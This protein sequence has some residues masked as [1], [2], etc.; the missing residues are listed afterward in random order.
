VRG[1][2]ATSSGRGGD[3][4]SLCKVSAR[5]ARGGHADSARQRGRSSAARVDPHTQGALAMKKRIAALTVSLVLVPAVGA[6]AQTLVPL[7]LSPARP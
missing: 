2:K 4:R 7:K 1:A 6:Q 5:E 3:A